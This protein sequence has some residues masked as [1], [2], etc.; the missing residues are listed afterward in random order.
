MPTQ[1]QTNLPGWQPSPKVKSFRRPVPAWFPPELR[2]VAGQKISFSLTGGERKIWRKKRHIQP[3]AW[4]EAHRV[5]HNSSLPGRWHNAVTP[6]IAGIMDASFHPAVRRVV[7]CKTPQTGGS[8]GILNCIGYIV[9]RCPGPTM[10]VYPDELMAR[11]NAR[12][13]LLPMLE[14]SRD[15]RRYFTGR[16]DDTSSLR[17]GLLNMTLH[18]AWSGSAARLGNKPVRYLV[19]EEIDKWQN[20]KGEASSLNLAE[21]RLTTWEERGGK[22]WDICTPTTEEGPIWVNLNNCAAVFD[23][24]VICPACGVA[25]LMRFEQIRWPNDENEPFRAWYECEHCRAEWDDSRRDKAVQLG[26]WV[27]R[28]SGLPL[29]HHLGSRRPKSI[30]FHIPA[31]ISHFVSLAKV[32]EAFLKYQRTKDLNDLKDFKN[33]FCA[34]PWVDYEVARSESKILALCDDRPRGAVPGPYLDGPLAGHP[35]VA[36][37]IAGVDTQ[38]EYLRYVIRAFG[39]GEEMPS[40]LVQCGALDSMQALERLL[41]HTQFFDAAGN[42]WQVH[43]AV[44]DAMGHH[45]Y[46]VYEFAARYRGL[47]LPYQGTGRASAPII[48]SPREYFPGT[49]VRIPSGVNLLR[50]DVPYF[51]SQLASKLEIAPSDPG[52]W[53]LHQQFDPASGSPLLDDYAREMC[54][55]YFDDEKQKWLCPPGKA[56]HYWDCEKMCLVGAHH[57]GIRNWL[58]PWAAPAPPPARPRQ[59]KPR[60]EPK[61]RW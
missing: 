32:S 30:G 28:E 36:A 23:Y 18:M 3:S 29:E 16:S 56:N 61:P 35:R 41:F 47:H 34:E 53:L 44:Q 25:Q 24:Q 2:R 13:R 21:A 38:G 17:I 39:W 58:P 26:R 59:R 50:C 31:W 48:L 52:A 22:M 5:V 57:L 42:P 37:L 43:L 33:R 4:A 6:Y 8:E 55:E 46:E 19:R 10:L 51:S 12:D 1:I 49:K 14:T 45:A 60:P 40:W 11:E 9:S 15:L 7:I 54:A 20:P 27:E